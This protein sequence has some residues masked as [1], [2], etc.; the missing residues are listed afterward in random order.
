MPCLPHSGAFPPPSDKNLLA[1]IHQLAC[2]FC[3]RSWRLFLSLA[4][5]LRSAHPVSSRCW[6]LTHSCSVPLQLVPVWH[7]GAFPPPSVKNFLGPMQRVPGGANDMSHYLMGDV[8][9]WI[10]HVLAREGVD[11]INAV[12]VRRRGVGALK[13]GNVAACARACPQGCRCH[14]SGA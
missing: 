12:P 5:I 3:P 14:Q 6:E 2:L 10:A 1:H 8:A 9:D 11:P 7:S 13:G 4:G